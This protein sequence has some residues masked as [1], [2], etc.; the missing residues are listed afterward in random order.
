[1]ALLELEQFGSATAKSREIRLWH[2]L[3]QGFS[4]VA[5]PRAEKFGCGTAK[6]RVI[7]LWH[8]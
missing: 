5:L 2:C 6:S 1:M 4:V 3:E 8:C 7:R